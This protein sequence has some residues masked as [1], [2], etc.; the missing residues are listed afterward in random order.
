MKLRSTSRSLW[1]PGTPGAPIRG[2]VLQGV[3]GRASEA[4]QAVPH[5]YSPTIGGV[6]LDA[7]LVPV[8]R[9]SESHFLVTCGSALPVSAF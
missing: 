6:R 8:L 7:R 4:L 3:E 2:S 9:T 5:L 1:C